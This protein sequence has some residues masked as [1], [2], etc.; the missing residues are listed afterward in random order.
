MI[1]VN[2]D[3]TERKREE[4]ARWEVNGALE[5]QGDLLQSREELLKI[6]VKH[7]PAA[8]AMLDRDMRYLQVSER[9]CADY[10]LDG[11]QILGRSHY[12]IFPDLPE[13]WKQVHRRGLEGQTLRAEEDRWDREGGTTWLR[14]EIRPWQN[15]DGR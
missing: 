13:Q 7:V 8:V 1:G 4:E 2:V 11:S 3:V 10:S 9:W 6:F 12:E 14:W 5:A 15:V